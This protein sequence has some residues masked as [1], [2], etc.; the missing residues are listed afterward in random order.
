MYTTLTEETSLFLKPMS[1]TMKRYRIN[2]WRSFLGQR[3]VLIYPP[4]W[5]SHSPLIPPFQI[6]DT[7][8]FFVSTHDV[9]RYKYRW[10][11]FSQWFSVII[12]MIERID[13]YHRGIQASRWPRWAI[14]VKYILC[15]GFMP[16]FSL[17]QYQYPVLFSIDR[18]T[19]V[20][21]TWSTYTYQ[22]YLK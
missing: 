12:S 11:W 22:C 10:K 21:Y 19:L 9:F 7:V 20:Q 8:L 3:T 5:Y 14:K 4:Y 13:F 6:K 2:A 15:F 18:Q 16:K 1:E 17:C